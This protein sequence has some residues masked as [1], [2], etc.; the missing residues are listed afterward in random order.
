MH[1]RYVAYNKSPTNNNDNNNKNLRWK[2]NSSWRN[3]H[4]N[5]GMAQVA[6]FSVGEAFN[7]TSPQGAANCGVHSPVMAVEYAR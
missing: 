5:D 4:L 6:A 7:T 1:V 2:G 3:P